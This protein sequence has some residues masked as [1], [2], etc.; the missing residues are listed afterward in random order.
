M[1]DAEKARIEQI[2]RS[3]NEIRGVH[4]L[5]T[6][7]SGTKPFMQMHIDLDAALTFPQAH[8]IADALEK[9][10]MENFPG[11]EIIVHPDL[12]D[13]SHNH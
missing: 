13:P 3:M 2:V 7:Y 5:K 4:N 11:A 6:R 10:L 1:P 8:A 12:H 9:K